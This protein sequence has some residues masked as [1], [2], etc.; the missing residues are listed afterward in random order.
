MRA[1]K[2]IGVTLRVYDGCYVVAVV[3]VGVR[4]GQRRKVQATNNNLQKVIQKVKG[5]VTRTPQE[6]DGE[7]SCSP[8]MKSAWTVLS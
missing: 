8:E 3:F 1:I 5:S 7:L 2:L 4:N 6:N